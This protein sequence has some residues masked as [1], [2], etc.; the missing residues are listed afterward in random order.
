LPDQIGERLPRF[1]F[2]INDIGRLSVSYGDICEAPV[3]EF[4]VITITGALSSVPSVLRLDLACI[5][6]LAA[7]QAFNDQAANMLDAECTL[8]SVDALLHVIGKLLTTS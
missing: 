1:I 2:L 4:V 5:V 8:Q 6:L 3:R 7:H